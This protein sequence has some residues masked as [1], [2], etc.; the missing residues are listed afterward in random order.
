[1]QLKVTKNL[2][3]DTLPSPYWI[4]T[5]VSAY[6]IY[7]SQK[8]KQHPLRLIV[9]ILLGILFLSSSVFSNSKTS[10]SI[11]EDQVGQIL[12]VGFRGTEITD[13]SPFAKMLY[14]LNLGG[15]VLF[16]Y[17]VPT[18][19][20][21]RNILDAEQTQKLVA[22]LQKSAKTPLLVAVDAEGG[23]INRLKKK[24][25]F[26]QIPSAQEMGTKSY[27]ECLN[28]YRTLAHQLQALGFNLNLAP[29]VDLN[30]NPQNPVIGSLERS[31]SE[32][33]QRVAECASAFITAHRENNLI[34]TLKH[35]PGHGSSREDSHLGLVDISRTYKS[36]ELQPYR[37]LIQKNLVATIMTAHIM[38]RKID[39]KFPATLSKEFIQSLLRDKLAF[40]GVVISDDMQMGAITENFGFAEALILAINA[41]CDLIA[42]ANNAKTY[43]DVL[44]L[45]AHQI[46]VEAVN[47][48]NIS[49]Q[50]IEEANTRIKRL[51]TKYGILNQ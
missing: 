33:P 8:L 39:P 7:L 17:D 38:N 13:N 44:P 10:D 46:I 11:L 3:Q 48:G 1:M 40:Q 45:R 31:F 16:D 47:T 29:V 36:L 23:R 41:G 15:V 5:N 35:F 25:G 19:S 37:D 26:L 21:P 24:Y 18:Q 20:F 32:D 4:L 30:L 42:L 27:L 51:K 28:I 12:L 49:R 6:V 43:D 50:R 14:E 9:C 34:T 22:D 2:L